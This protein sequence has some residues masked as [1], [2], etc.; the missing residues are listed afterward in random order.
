MD[1]SRFGL[2]TITRRRLTLPGVKPIGQHQFEFD[3][4]QLYGIVAPRTGEGYFESRL[5]MKAAEFSDFLHAF[6]AEFPHRFHIILLDN[7]RSHH[8]KALT[9]PPNV[10]LLF[11]PPYAP[12]LNPVERVWLALKSQLAWRCFPSLLLLQDALS[13]LIVA[14]DP[15]TLRS[16]TAYPFLRHAISALTP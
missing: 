8:A 9:L 10:R 1:E 11:L 14:L 6:A 2:Q 7:A 4:F 3:N 12:E 13:D 15:P 16:L 5:S